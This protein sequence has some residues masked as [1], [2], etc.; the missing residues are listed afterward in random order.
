MLLN[1]QKKQML[2]NLL[3]ENAV[4]PCIPVSL[5]VQWEYLSDFRCFI[6]FNRSF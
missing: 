4:Q 5:E 2:S 6:D 1:K 3:T